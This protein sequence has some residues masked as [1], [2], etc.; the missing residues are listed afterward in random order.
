M[1][2]SAKM[3]F[4]PLRNY[5]RKILDRVGLYGR[6]KT[7]WIYDYYWALVDKQVVDD[8]RSEV[9]FYRNLLAGFR[10]GDVVFDVG[11]NHGYKTD[12]FLRLGARVVSIEPDE[13]SQQILRQNF[14]Q[15]RLEKKPLVIVNQAV[16]DKSSIERMW[17]DVPGSAKNTLS[18]KWADTLRDDPTRFGQTLSFGVWKNVETTTIAQLITRCGWPFFIK[19]DVE[20]HE[21][22]VLRGMQKAVPY[23]SF[24]VNLPEF[25]SE[26]LE[27]VRVLA[28]LARSGK[29]NYTTDCRHGLALLNWVAA[30]E[31]EAVFTSCT[32]TCVEVFWKTPV[33]SDESFVEDPG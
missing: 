6:V 4:P 12:I 16:S 3:V 30:P 32:E 1:P 19:I 15:Y 28:R 21:L 27:C 9:D 31:F 11:A 23:L 22:N 2:A 25:R 20:G 17:I 24:E 26:G 13:A 10:E 33:S 18:K 29:F 8:R 7:S 5:F 14:Q